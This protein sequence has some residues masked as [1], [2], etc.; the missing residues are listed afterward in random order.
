[1]DLAVA[2][3]FFDNDPLYDAYT[4]VYLYDGQFATYDGAQLDGS[5]IRR[6]TVSL[7]PELVLPARRVVTLYDEQ[8]VLSDP[9]RDGFQ[10]QVIRQTMSARKCHH[11]YSILNAAELL[12]AP[13][14]PRQAYAFSRWTKNTAE[15]ATSELEPYYEFSFALSETD[16]YGKFFKVGDNIWHARMASEV[17]E[18]FM[19]VEADL[20]AGGEKPGGPVTVERP[21][22]RDP[23]TL[24]NSPSTQHP[25]LLIERYQFFRRLD[26]AQPLN[27]AGDKT[28][29]VEDIPEFEHQGEV[30][31]AGETWTVLARQKLEGGYG[32]HIRRVA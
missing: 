28:L 29:I 8:W 32:L 2:S 27:Y 4:G 26:Q 22:V 15:A 16:L 18:G 20:L 30:V 25:G 10:G 11:L 7:A 21:G 31:I 1:M 24:T 3:S 5:F 9:I 6:R 19:F 23:I 12:Q 13:A 14:T 17:A